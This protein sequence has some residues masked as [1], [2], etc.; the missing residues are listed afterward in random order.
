MAV[1]VPAA[2]PRLRAA[3]ALPVPDA[4]LPVAFAESLQT[5][6]RDLVRVRPTIMTGVP[7]VFEKFHHAVLDRGRRPSDPEG[8]VPLGHG[9][10]LAVSG[11]R[12]PGSGRHWAV[13]QRR[14]PTARSPQGPGANG[15]PRAALGVGERAVGPHDRG[16]LLRGGGAD[17]RGIRPDGEFARHHRR[18]L[19]APS[20]WERSASRFRASRSGSP[21]TARCSRAG[22]TSCRATSTGLRRPRR[23]C[24]TGG[25]TPATSATWTP[26]VPDDHRSQEGPDRHVGRQEHRACSD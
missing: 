18:T 14:W 3:C 2:E 13:L 7:R 26:T 5:V 23:P 6:A 25:C 17:Q 20:A 4:R 10:G 9:V 11:A 8:A 22:R 16:V 24:A 12:W 15:R 19:P 1:V 21:A